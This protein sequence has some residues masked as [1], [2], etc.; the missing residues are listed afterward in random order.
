LQ[1]NESQITS[2]KGEESRGPEK[3]KSNMSSQTPW[4]HIQPMQRLTKEIKQ[5]AGNISKK[6]R[7][8]ENEHHAQ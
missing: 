7:A 5:I 4:Y 6:R 2:S 3:Q 1:N 8:E